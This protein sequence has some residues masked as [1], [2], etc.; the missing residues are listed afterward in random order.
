MRRVLRVALRLHGGFE[1]VGEAGDGESAVAA[2]ERHQ[3]DIVILD[4]GLPR[5]AGKDLLGR[6]RDRVPAAK[7]V[8]YTGTDLLNNDALRDRVE[9]YVTKDSDVAHL[10]SVLD[11]LGGSPRGAAVL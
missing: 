3:P 7:V 2:A 4:L 1:V 8:V 11:H 6:L 5:L 9:G 10:L